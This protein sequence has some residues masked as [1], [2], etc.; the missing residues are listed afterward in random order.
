MHCNKCVEL[1]ETDG[2]RAS[3]ANT[4]MECRCLSSGTA[5]TDN[6]DDLYVASSVQ[7]IV[8]CMEVEFVRS[9]MRR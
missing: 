7:L 2:R 1:F 8:A 4:R 5:L 6:S 3:N 9:A